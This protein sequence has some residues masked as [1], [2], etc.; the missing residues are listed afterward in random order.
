[1]LER[2]DDV[3]NNKCSMQ[4]QQRKPQVQYL[5]TE[6]VGL[7]RRCPAPALKRPLPL[8]VWLSAPTDLDVMLDPTTPLKDRLTIEIG[9]FVEHTQSAVKLA[10]VDIDASLAQ[11]TACVQTKWPT[12]TATCFGSF[13]SGLWLP[14]SDIDVVIQGIIDDEATLSDDYQAQVDQLDIIL[15]LLLT[16]DWVARAVVVGTKVPVIKLDVVGSGRQI[17]IAVETPHTRQGLRAT[18]VVRAGVASMV[19]MYPLVLV[20][21]SFLREKGLNNAFLGGLSSYA[22]VLLCLHYLLTSPPEQSVGEAVLGFLEYYG[23][24]FDH[25]M[26]CITWCIDDEGRL[27]S[28]EYFVPPTMKGALPVPRLVLDDPSDLSECGLFNV[29]AGANALARVVAAIE[30]AFYAITFHRPT[31]FTPT[32]LSQVIHWSGP[33]AL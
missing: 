30:N 31:R 16:K 11:L 32:P 12:A 15:S 5:P 20:L 10:Q 21:K 26:T 33:S 24:V 22:L 27:L 9:R 4:E 7:P 1:M 6:D 29:G 23:T 14:S 28:R 13:A 25:T 17:D 8:P 2:N 18:E 19:Q 3:G